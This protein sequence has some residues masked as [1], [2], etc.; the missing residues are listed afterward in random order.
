MAAEVMVRLLR[1]R[2]ALAGEVPSPETDFDGK[3]LFGSQVLPIQG[4]STNLRVGSSNCHFKPLTS[5]TGELYIF[6]DVGTSLLHV[7]TGRLSADLQSLEWSNGRVWRRVVEDNLL[8]DENR[9]LSEKLRRSQD[10]IHRL[11][12]ALNA[13]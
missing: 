9:R 7:V 5:K 12:G 11:H 1:N 8:Q 10:E 2:A 4:R 3:W 13:R 6:D